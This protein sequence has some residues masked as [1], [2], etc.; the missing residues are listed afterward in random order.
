MVMNG[1]D[2]IVPRVCPIWSLSTCT[3]LVTPIFQIVGTYIQ[4]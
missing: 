4:K 3:T 2:N 1:V